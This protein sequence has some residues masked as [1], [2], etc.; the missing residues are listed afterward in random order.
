MVLLS[1]LFV[2]FFIHDRIL[3]TRKGAAKGANLEVMQ[4]VVLLSDHDQEQYH[5]YRCI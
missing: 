1:I 5:L 2:R 4:E 3:A